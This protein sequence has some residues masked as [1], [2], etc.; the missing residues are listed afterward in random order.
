[1]N[2]LIALAAA[3]AYARKNRITAVIYSDIM[4]HL[5][6]KHGFADART[7]EKPDFSALCIGHKQIYNLNSGFKQLG[8]GLLLI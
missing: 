3:L 7:A 1:M 2:K 4:N 6:N 8:S 5:H